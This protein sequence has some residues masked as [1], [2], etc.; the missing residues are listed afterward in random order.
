MALGILLSLLLVLIDALSQIL[1]THLFR[2]RRIFNV[3]VGL[4]FASLLIFGVLYVK[5]SN[6]PS[7]LGFANGLVVYALLYGGYIQCFY[8]VSQP[9]TLRMLEEFLKTPGGMLQISGLKE[10]YGLEHMI[11]SRLETLV[12][13]GHA[14]KEGKRYLLT[15]K[16][17]FL[18]RIFKIFRKILGTPYYLDTETFN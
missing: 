4:F 11:H 10:N 6:L 3:F 15:G 8:Y 9:V 1:L 14:M 18:A 13:N 7:F 12:L 16:G 2:P 5:I 17:K